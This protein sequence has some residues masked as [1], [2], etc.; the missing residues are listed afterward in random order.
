[1]DKP[2]MIKQAMNWTYKHFTQ[3]TGNY[4]LISGIVG[5][6]ASCVNQVVAIALNKKIPK[7]QKYFLF[8]QEITDGIVNVS[9]FA[10]LTRS[11]TVVGER[12]AETGRIMKPSIRKQLE[13]FNLQDKIGTDNFNI[14]KIA[15]M[16]DTNKLKYD[17]EFSKEF[18]RFHKGTAFMFSTLGA[19]VACDF[20]TPFVRNKIAS[21]R[22]KKALERDE[23]RALELEKISAPVLPAQNDLGGKTD[24][25]NNPTMNYYA[26]R[27][28]TGGNMKI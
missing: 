17:K 22:Q 21:A 28:T 1:M 15:Q 2:P 12:L 9:L 18:K 24:R 7:E 26:T 20:V 25:K 3:A 16:D 8:P 27:I 14:K 11:F 19:I 5:W 10:L 23:Q 13:S 4:M 6:A